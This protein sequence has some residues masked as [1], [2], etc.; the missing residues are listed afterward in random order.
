MKIY[1]Q[2]MRIGRWSGCHQMEERS[3]NFK[4]KPFP[5]CA[6]CTGVLFGNI[7]AFIMFLIYALPIWICLLGCLV[8]FVDWFIQYLKIR[9]STNIRRLITGIIGGYCLTTLWCMVI[10]YVI[11]LFRS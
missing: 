3:F 8:M 10:Q 5:V 7:S 1:K 2:L 11:L 6:R 4:G 9:E